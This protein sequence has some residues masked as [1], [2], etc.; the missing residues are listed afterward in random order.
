MKKN[1]LTIGAKAKAASKNSITANLKNKVLLKYVNLINKNRDKIINENRK[2]II[3]AQKKG[4]RQNMIKR[5]ELNKKNIDQIILSIK[6]IIKL[7]DPVDKAL[8][9]WSVKKIFEELNLK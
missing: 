3:K 6:N 1:L 9:S 7:S 2:D 5:L 4:L 8:A